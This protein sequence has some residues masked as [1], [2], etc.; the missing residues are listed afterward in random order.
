MRLA[1]FGAVWT[2]A[3]RPRPRPRRAWV[4]C[5]L[6]GL[7]PW[8]LWGLAA[9]ADFLRAEIPA[10]PAALAGAYA[11]FEDGVDAF[12]W[13]PAA[14]GAVR[15]PEVGATHYAGILDTSYN[16]ANFVQPLS[17]WGRPVGLGLAVQNS[18]TAN[19]DQIDNNGDNLGAVENY[20]LVLQIA[21]GLGLSETLRVG[22]GA[23]TFT[24]RLAEYRARGFAVDLGGQARV[25]PRVTLG[26]ALVDVGTQEAYDQ[27][28]DPLPTLFRLAGRWDGWR[29]EEGAVALA[30]ELDRPW[31]TSGPI[32]LGSGLEY[33]YKNT[34]AFRTGW[35]LGVDLGPFSLGLGFKWQGF[36]LDYAYN[37]LGELGFTHRVGLSAQV[38][39]LFR[40]LGLTVDPIEGE[41]PHAETV[42]RYAA[43]R[44][45][46]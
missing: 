34:L 6:L 30:L 41:R 38:G 3:V 26:A 35:R 32:T 2:F 1:A 17:V 46:R 5:A 24:S 42:P 45:L 8:Q 25:H 29:D 36:N 40:R 27:V 14:L 21:A 12:L 15:Q 7:A 9:G 16:L 18:S 11:A 22:L 23:K 44:E 4:L 10:R 13:N 39:T 19:F 43:P 37:S 20:D 31:S 28:A 33:W